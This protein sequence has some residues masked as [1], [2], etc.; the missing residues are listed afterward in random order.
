MPLYLCNSV[1]GAIQDAAK[2][3]IA[4][5]ITRIHCALTGAPAKF[6]HAFFL[7]NAPNHSLDGKSICLTGNIRAGRTKTQKD[8]IKQQIL[9]S[10]ATHTG[11]DRKEVIVRIVDTPASWV[12]EGGEV[13]PEPGEEE[14][15]MIKYEAK[16]AAEAAH[17]SD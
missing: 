2:Q 15:W 4:S 1:T 7:E 10:I 16:L 11:H 6:V 9:D 5:D 17:K 8:N 3:K 14:E 12:M 13:F